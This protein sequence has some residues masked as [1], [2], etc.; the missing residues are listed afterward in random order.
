MPTAVV[1]SGNNN[2]AMLN[3]M[4]ASVV[5]MFLK[6]VKNAIEEVDTLKMSFFKTISEQGNV[7]YAFNPG[8]RKA[9][10]GRLL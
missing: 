4:Q 2:S 3:I 8:T 7:V 6:T 5:L 9:E 1:S 10:A